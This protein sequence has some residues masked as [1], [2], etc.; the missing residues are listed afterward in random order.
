[1]RGDL[2]KGCQAGTLPDSYGRVPNTL[3]PCRRN[4]TFSPRLIDDR[5]EDRAC[6]ADD[7]IVHAGKSSK[8]DDFR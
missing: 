4:Y 8:K 1:M 3:P 5:T 7:E 2:L 6:G